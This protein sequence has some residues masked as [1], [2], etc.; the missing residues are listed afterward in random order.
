M[1]RRND[2]DRRDSNITAAVSYSSSGT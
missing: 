2:N 1:I